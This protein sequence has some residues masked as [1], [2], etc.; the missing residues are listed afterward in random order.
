M[1]C[2]IK[3]QTLTKNMYKSDR[4]RECDKDKD[5]EVDNDF[6]LYKSSRTGENDKEEVW[7]GEVEQEGVGE[8]AQGGGAHDRRDHQEGTDGGHL[9]HI[10]WLPYSADLFSKQVSLVGQNN[11]C[12]FW[13]L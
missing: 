7:D 11:A 10:C 3:T 5:F 9:V 12:L 1:F 2:N 13:S 8:L 4:T 6:H